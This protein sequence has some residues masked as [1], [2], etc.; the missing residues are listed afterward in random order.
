MASSD[1]SYPQAWNEEETLASFRNGNLAGVNQDESVLPLSETSPSENGGNNGNDVGLSP[2]EC[3][4]NAREGESV[5]CNSGEVPRSSFLPARDIDPKLTNG[6]GTEEPFTSEAFEVLSDNQQIVVPRAAREAE[7]AARP[8]LTEVADAVCSSP[9]RGHSQV[10]ERVSKVSPLGGALYGNE[11]DEERS[12]EQRF[13]EALPSFAQPPSS[14]FGIEYAEDSAGGGGFS[15]VTESPDLPHR[16]YEVEENPVDASEDDPELL[17]E[18]GCENQH[19]TRVVLSRS[20]RS[21]LVDSAHWSRHER[22]LAQFQ[23]ELESVGLN[24][25]EAIR[26]R[27]AFP[28]FLKAWAQ[29]LKPGD[30]LFPSWFFMNAAKLP[31]AIRVN[32]RDY[33]YSEKLF[34]FRDDLLKG[35][36]QAQ[37]T[38]HL[39]IC[40]TLH[41]STS[42]TSAKPLPSRAMQASGCDD[43]S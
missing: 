39:V 16:P 33:R 40:R 28:R 4:G 15:T 38:Y 37:E 25:F 22:L 13:E 34:R 6:D 18:E 19:R 23:K 11:N 14:H 29:K 30:E 41:H 36:I 10:P 12:R 32:G 8:Q 20:V 24:T 9:R 35:F 43:R 3:G 5:L 7:L 21:L 42:Q 2:D 27:Q 1:A 17:V 26:H 31:T